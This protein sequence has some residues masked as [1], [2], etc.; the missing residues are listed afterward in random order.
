MRIT[1]PRMK[2]AITD[3]LPI[4]KCRKIHS[5]LKNPNVA[6]FPLAPH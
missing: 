5:W 2:M 6:V 1:E 4:L 3:P